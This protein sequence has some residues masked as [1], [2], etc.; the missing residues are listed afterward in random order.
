[1]NIFKKKTFLIT[2]YDKVRLNQVRDWCPA[3]T[4]N[5]IYDNIK[6]GVV[7]IRYTNGVFFKYNIPNLIE[8][9]KF[10]F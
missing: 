5:N 9:F 4:R 3:G 10:L 1:M 8:L 2:I 7:V 6:G